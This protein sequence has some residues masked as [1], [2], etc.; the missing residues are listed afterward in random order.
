MVESENQKTIQAI[1]DKQADFEKGIELAMDASRL[2]AKEG[3]IN[4][5][6]T[7]Q[8][9]YDSKKIREKLEREFGKENVKSTAVGDIHPKTG[10]KILDIKEDISSTNIIIEGTK[11]STKGT[12]SYNLYYENPGHHDPKGKNNSPYNSTKSVLPNNHMELW[13][14]SIP[15]Q[16]GRR[17]AIERTNN[18]I[19]YHR[20]QTDPNTGVY[21]W[22]GSTNGKTASGVERKISINEI[23]NFIKEGNK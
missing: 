6:K 9:L 21:H 17:W 3:D 19:I 23:P 4:N 8:S 7:K 15:D 11:P 20:F 1:K 14:N 2:F 13:K 12:L 5:P 16:Q 22:N 10:N 18:E